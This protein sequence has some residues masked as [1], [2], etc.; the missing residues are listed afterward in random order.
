VRD[1]GLELTVEAVKTAATAITR[2][3]LGG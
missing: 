3:V 1:A 2:Q